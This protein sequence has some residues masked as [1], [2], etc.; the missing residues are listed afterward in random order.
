MISPAGHFPSPLELEYEE[1]KSTIKP[2]EKITGDVKIDSGK[3]S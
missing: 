1:L 3:S 2:G